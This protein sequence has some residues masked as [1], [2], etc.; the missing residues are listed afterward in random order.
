VKIYQTSFAPATVHMQ[1]CHAYAVTREPAKALTAAQ[2]VGPGDLAGISYGRHLLDVAQAHADARHPT[3]A[4]A[5]LTQARTV[6]PVWF[7]HQGV[8][9]FLVTDLCEQQKRLSPALRELAASVDPD[10]YAPYHRHGE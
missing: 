8:A 3:A 4:T 6:A 1:A 9:R 7:R 2:K 5:V 10:W